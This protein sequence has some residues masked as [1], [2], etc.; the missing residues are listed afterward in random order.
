MKK[1][2]PIILLLTVTVLSIY[3]VTTLRQTKLSPT[4]R[5]PT[6]MTSLES[7]EEEEGEG[8]KLQ[9]IGDAMRQEFEKTKDPVLNRV[10][11]ERLKTALKVLKE[12]QRSG[13]KA[14]I[15]NIFWAERGP[16]N[17]GGRTRGIWIDPNN[18]DRVLSAGVGGGLFETTNFTS[19][20][21]TWTPQ[22][23]FFAN[24]AI[25][26]IAQVGNTDVLFFGTG[27]GWFN[28]GA[29]RGLGIW[30]ST[31]RGNSWTQLQST[32]NATFSY[33]QKIK[34]DNAGNIYAATR[35]GGLQ[36]STDNG[37]SWTQVVGRNVNR[38]GT[39]RAADVEISV[40]GDIYVSLGVFSQGSVWKSSNNG[41]TWINATPSGS[42]ERIE[43]ATAPSDNNRVYILCQGENSQNAD[44]IFRSDDAGNSWTALPVP[45]IIDQGRNS[46]FTRGQAW[47]DLIAAV[48]PND[49]NKVYIAGVD[50]LRS[51]DAGA[52]W[53]QISTW[54]LNNAPGYTTAQNLHADHHEILFFPGSSSQ[55]ISGTDGGLAY[56]TNMNIQG[57]NNF[58]DWTAKN[59]GYNVT[60]YYACALHPD[61]DTDYFL[62]GAQDNGTQQYSGAGVNSTVRVTGGDG[63]FC[64]I[65]QDN[66]DIQITAFTRNSY[67]L[68]TN[69]GAS[70]TSFVREDGGSFI[71]PTDYDNDADV[72]YAGNAR[73]SYFRWNNPSAAGRSTDVV[74]VSTFNDANITHV[75]TSPNVANRVYF[76]LSNGT[77]ARIDNADTGT[78]KTGSVLNP[79]SNGSI[80]CVAIEIGNEQHLLATYSNYGVTSIYESTNGG[81]SWTS[82]EGNLPDMP[83]RWA[84][85][86]PNNPDQALIAT[87][88]GVWSTDDLRTGG[89]T[90]WGPTNMGLA[91]VRTDMLQ[92]RP[93]DDMVIAATHGRGLY[94]TSSFGILTVGFAEASSTAS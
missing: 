34:V 4:P 65:D 21:T 41:R 82:V 31:D 53:E 38:G 77:I 81:S 39:D 17:V 59:K 2:F 40:D 25:T 58:P 12:R 29:V 37:A 8:D 47:Y 3:Y 54:A 71:N 52:N 55:A 75:M 68:S 33:V 45:T 18:T 32:N 5:L 67:S 66:P 80:S 91:N 86:H 72:L 83:V 23:D 88:L 92:H 27:E 22:D 15:P 30:Q 89:T 16:D 61:T 35:A 11:R 1:T 36:R 78:A 26:T 50:M 28:G 44:N 93:S 9:N 79:G 62:A 46:N 64:H 49:A 43:I 74:T 84:M 42:F 87:E 76:G 56:T 51:T 48:D 19:N 94:S 90:N 70:F 7:E 69:G 6:T 10:P 14:A 20:S 63:G 13:E 24:L 85:F 73:G 60:Q 57:N